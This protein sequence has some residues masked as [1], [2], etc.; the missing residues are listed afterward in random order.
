[1]GPNIEPCETPV[2]ITCDMTWN[3]YMTI[4]NIILSLQ[5]NSTV[6]CS[7]DF[8]YH[9]NIYDDKFQNTLWNF[10][11]MKKCIDSCLERLNLIYNKRYV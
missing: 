7:V 6:L 5:Y 1:M 9:A 3:Y 11:A 2:I 8:N 10:I 4:L